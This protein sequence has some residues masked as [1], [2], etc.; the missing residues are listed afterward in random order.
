MQGTLTWLAQRVDENNVVRRGNALRSMT[1]LPIDGLT[2]AGQMQLNEQERAFAAA[3]DTVC[4]ISEAVGWPRIRMLDRY[5]VSLE[6]VNARTVRLRLGQPLSEG[7]K[8]ALLL[9]RHSD[10]QSLTIQGYVASR[11]DEED[12]TA[13]IRVSV[14]SRT[15]TP[16]LPTEDEASVA[17]AMHA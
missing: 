2:A 14:A 9:I 8:L 12:D 4:I 3:C 6:V 15:W 1:E 13:P 11:A 7:T 5:A 10:G 17:R 16:E